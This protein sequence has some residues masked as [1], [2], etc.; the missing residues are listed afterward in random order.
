M[1]QEEPELCDDL[2]PKKPESTHFMIQEDDYDKKSLSKRRPKQYFLLWASEASWC[3]VASLLL[4]LLV[5]ALLQFDGKAQPKWPLGLSLNTLIAFLSTICRCIMIHPIAEGLLQLKW[6]WFAVIYAE[7][8][9]LRAAERSL[10]YR[11][12]EDDGESALKPH[13][14]TA[15]CR[16]PIFSSLAVCVSMGNVTEYLTKVDYYMTLPGEFGRVTSGLNVTSPAYS[17]GRVALDNP[18]ATEPLYKWN[19]SDIM[20]LSLARAF[21]LYGIRTN[22][23]TLFEAVEVVWHYCVNTYNIS[24][25]NNIANTELLASELTVNHRREKDSSSELAFTLL[26][27]NSHHEFNISYLFM[28]SGFRRRLATTI[29]GYFY[30]S[31]SPNL[32]NYNEFTMRANQVNGTVE[33]DA[34]ESEIFITVRWPWISFL[35]AQIVLTIAFISAVAASTSNLEVPVIKGSNAAELFAIRKSDME[36][37][38]LG[39]V[40]GKQAGID[41]KIDKKTLGILVRDYDTWHLEIHSKE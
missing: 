5:F 14:P 29:A 9:M 8:G 40:N 41:Q 12:D 6:N 32:L 18:N 16:W 11:I 34:L 38:T 25:T 31:S 7:D 33:G 21:F 1:D 3:L 2:T 15:N 39:T 27:K 36:T 35:A 26:A 30:E 4:G 20:A 37:T 24:V 10:I 22:G 28:M 19:N 23:T 17:G 13:C